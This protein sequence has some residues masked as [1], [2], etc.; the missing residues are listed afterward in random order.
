MKKQQQQQQ[1]QLN[2][3]SDLVTTQNL[4]IHLCKSTCLVKT[5]PV[6]LLPC[7]NM[8][9]PKGHLFF[10]ETIALSKLVLFKRLVSK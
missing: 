9:C 4:V 7:Q 10:K 2:P 3:F 1:Q 8:F 6:K 5:C